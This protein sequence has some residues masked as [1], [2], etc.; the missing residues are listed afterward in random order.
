MKRIAL[1]TAAL[2][3]LSFGLANAQDILD[4]A[5]VPAGTYEE[6]GVTYVNTDVPVTFTMML[7]VDPSDPA[8]IY[9]VTNGWTVYLTD[10]GGTPLANALSLTAYTV[11]VLDEAYI[12][13]AGFGTGFGF[14]GGQ[15]AT[16]FFDGT[17]PEMLGVA[18]FNFFKEGLP[19]GL[20]VADYVTITTSTFPKA[21]YDGVGN[22]LCIDSAFYPPGGYWLWSDSDP[23]DR[24]PFWGGPYCW[25]IKSQLD[26]PPVFVNCGDVPV[27]AVDHCSAFSFT[28]VGE[29]SGPGAAGVTYGM[30]SGPGDIDPVTGTYTLAGSMALVGSPIDITVEV[31]DAIGQTDECAFQVTFSNQAPTITCLGDFTMGVNTSSTLQLSAGDPDVCDTANLT[32]SIAGVTP[33]PE[34][35]YSITADGALTFEP[36]VNDEAVFT[37]DIVVTDGNLTATCQQVIEAVGQVP[38]G[39]YI[40]KA[41]M[42]IQGAHKIIDVNMFKGSEEMWGFD[43]LIAYDASVLSFQN[44]IRGDLYPREVND[45]GCDWEYF[46]YRYGA[47]GN[48]GNACPSGLLRVVGIAETNNGAANPNFDCALPTEYT[49]FSLDFLVSDNRTY[50]CQYA[51]VRFFWMDCGDNTISFHPVTAADDYSQVLAIGDNVWDYAFDE[52]GNFLGDDPAW[53]SAGH[54][55]LP[56]DAEWPTYAGPLAN[57]DTDDDT[58]WVAVDSFIV[59]PGTIPLIDFYNGGI[60]IAC[61]HEIDDRGDLNLDGQANT[62]ADAV[63]YSNYFVYGMGVFTVNPDG[64]IAASDINADGLP[65]SVA[66]LVY[67]IR[68]VVGDALPYDDPYAPKLSPIAADLSNDKGTLSIDKLM[69]AAYVVVEGQVEPTLL[70]ADVDMKFAYDAAANV[71][72]VLVVDLDNATPFQGEFLQVNGTVRSIEMASYEGAPV[73]LKSLPTS[74]ALNQNYPNP[75][76]PATTIS[77]DLPSQMDYTIT[78]YNV[79]GQV[80][81]TNSGNGQGTINWTFDASDLSSGIYFYNVEAGSNSATKK[82]VLIK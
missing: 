40:E 75:F 18:G 16:E 23:K 45:Y 44:A 5:G 6:G 52:D 82:M 58:N 49:L 10:G 66:D 21:E 12:D 29:D 71:T 4:L 9:G 15:P 73:T 19:S 11:K 32:F 54:A 2:M 43:F 34:G 64:Q 31:I 24:E 1:F 22:Q 28:F 37:F 46:T 61:A 60:D 65:L 13:A 72:R 51:P 7:A 33:V 38:F 70:A 27:T 26:P 8:N 69:G 81:A 3:I 67:L 36:T 77:F 79:T 68:V 39:V 63:L 53:I 50:E 62:I 76:N 14:D 30:V 56:Y 48:C 55:P 78:V 25:T 20:T 17:S 41:E 42:V 59:K 57:C 35:A 47:N 80:V 74:F